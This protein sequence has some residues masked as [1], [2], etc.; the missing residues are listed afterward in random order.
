MNTRMVVY[1]YG[2][3]S[4]YKVPT[5]LLGMV[6]LTKLVLTQQE[7]NNIGMCHIDIKIVFTGV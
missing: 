5:L 2:S 7:I 1:G 4:L 3:I 6:M